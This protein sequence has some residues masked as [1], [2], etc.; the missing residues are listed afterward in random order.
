MLIQACQE[1]AS[2]R[3]SLPEDKSLIEL[4]DAGRGNPKESKHIVLERPH[5]LLLLSSVFGGRALRG[6]YTGAFTKQLCEADGRLEIEQMQ[7]RARIH[8]QEH[9]KG[10][11]TQIPEMRSTLMKALRLPPPNKI[12]EPQNSCLEL[13]ELADARP[14]PAEPQTVS[15]HLQTVLTVQHVTVDV[16]PTA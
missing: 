8:M 11:S 9:H 3:I 10:S 12:P 1:F 14:K 4:N 2:I 6:A 5:T 16:H 15:A 7:S 13:P